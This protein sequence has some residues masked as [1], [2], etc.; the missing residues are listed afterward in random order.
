M[1]NIIH[2]KKFEFV[3][4]LAGV[5][6][7]ALLFYTPLAN[8]ISVTSITAPLT[9]GDINSDKILDGTIVNA[10]VSNTANIDSNKLRINGSQGYV[11]VSDGANIATTTGF[12]V[13]TSTGDVYVFSARLHASTTNFNGQNLT[14]PS[15][16]GSNTYALTTDGAGTLSWSASA[17]SALD[18]S[19]TAGETLVA[20]NAVFM[21]TSTTATSTITTIATTNDNTQNI[22]RVGASG[23]QQCQSTTETPARYIHGIRAT[24]KTAGS[25]TDNFLVILRP[26]EG[27]DPGGQS[28]AT[29]T[30]PAATLTGTFVAYD[31][32]FASPQVLTG[33]TKYWICFYRSGADD[34]TNYYQIAAKD[35]SSEYANG[36][37]FL[38][39]G[40]WVASGRDYVGYAFLQYTAGRVYRTLSDTWDHS[41]SFIGF[42]KTN[43]S[44]GASATVSVNG[45]AIGL[46]GLTA[47]HLYYTS[48][49]LGGVSSSAG[50]FSRKVGI[51]ISATTM[52][53]TNQW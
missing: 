2:K 13:A 45:V 18:I 41:Q 32:M 51:G 31:F 3:T 7:G 1:H 33:A 12:K 10:D 20:G 34:D 23:S 8:A 52:L 24:V 28:L 38:Y 19:V 42:V 40:S 5:L 44:A 6:I 46:S 47:G 37:L 48:S 4:F 17:P 49:T 43:A 22:G 27:T 11:L 26:N 16:T 39:N 9:T 50:T 35:A 36:E 21:A 53:I 15:D 14:W 25:P 30:R 29:S